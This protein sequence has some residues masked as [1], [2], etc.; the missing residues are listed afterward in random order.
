MDKMFL[1]SIDASLE[2]K[3]F[4]ALMSYFQQE[5]Y[6][7]GLG[8]A[9]FQI[10]TICKILLYGNESDPNNFPSWHISEKTIF[11][12]YHK[13]SLEI[14]DYLHLSSLKLRKE[15]GQY[16]TPINIVRHILKSAGFSHSK[17][18]LDKKLIDP[19]CGSGAFLAESVRIYL[20]SLKKADIPIH[21]WYP[22]VISAVSG[23]D[24]DPAACFFARINL[25]ILLAPA[26]LESAT[27]Y[28]IRAIKP[29]PVYCADTLKIIASELKGNKMLYTEQTLILTNRFDFV[30]GNP[31]YF[32]VK[33]LHDDLKEVFSDSVYGHPNA[34]A[35]FL[36]AGIEMLK[37]R[38]RLGFIIPRSML[39]GLYFKNL[40]SFIEQKTSV[41]E[42]VYI[43]DRKKVF[44]D[45]LHGTMVL[46][47]ERN[48]HHHR[49][50]NISYAQTTKELEDNISFNVEREK[51]IQRLNGTTVWFVSDSQETYDIINR[52]IKRHPL[53]SGHEVNCRA[54]TGQIVWNRVKPLLA[55]DA[56][57]DSLSLIWATDVSKFGFSFNRMGEDRPSFLRVNE[58][59]KGLIVKDPCIL[60]QR[61]T[62]DE[63]PSRIVACIPEGFCKE[64]KDGYFVENHLNIIQ[65]VV[66]HSAA[67][68]YF[69]LGVLNSEIVDFF[70]RAMNGNTQVSATELNLLPI[71]TG[72]Y[73]QSIAELAKEMQKATDEGKRNRLL[74]ELNRLTAMAYGLTA[75]EHEFIR[76]RLNYKYKCK[77]RRRHDS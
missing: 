73:E 20:H 17:D 49:T 8:I 59:T 24:I 53:L 72:K 67:D 33:D 21:K 46:C 26:V 1:S 18:I 51:V 5:N 3:F 25:S 44:D 54:K 30:V 48:K 74:N 56:K 28:G 62:A 60:V 55:K 29:L 42:I 40:R 75:K 41:R 77:N 64:N 76:E 2:E 52:I 47:L 36:H 45:V 23:I 14:L 39:S 66:A 68:L 19:A 71:P 58:K 10:D 12:E 63:Q 37:E 70:F 34:Y 13:E 57:K 27:K 38:G 11:D 50:V 9:D 4:N 43:S 61:I 32:K 16:A 65:P 7:L 6:K 15:L 69:I 35:L 22:M 31:P